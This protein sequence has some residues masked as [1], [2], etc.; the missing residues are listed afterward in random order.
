MKVPTITTERLTLRGFQESDA[1]PLHRL[2]DD[3]EVMRYFPNP[4]PPTR[5][6]VERLV[7]LQIKHWEEHGYGWWAVELPETGE[8]IGWNGL[9]FLPETDETEIGYLLGKAHWGRGLATDGVRVPDAGAGAHRGHR[10][11]GEPSVAAGP[12]KAGS[13]ADRPGALLWDGLPALCGREGWLRRARGGRAESVVRE[14]GGRTSLRIESAGRHQT[15][16]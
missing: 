1:G 10:A 5:E 3:D 2:M 13:V 8:L 9:Q 7:G 16:A 6:Q 4:N 14:L 11:P 12:G 15:V